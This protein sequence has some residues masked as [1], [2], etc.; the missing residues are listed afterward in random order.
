MLE[1]LKSQTL[2]DHQGMHLTFAFQKIEQFGSF[3]LS[4]AETIKEGRESLKA[5]FSDQGWLKSTRE[6]VLFISAFEN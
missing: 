2:F 1:Y 3:C 5:K 6:L 4:P